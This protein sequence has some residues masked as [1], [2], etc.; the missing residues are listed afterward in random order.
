MKPITT[1]T[2]LAALLATTSTLVWSQQTTGAPVAE[3]AAT[4]TVSAPVATPPATSPEAAPIP[5]RRV[6]APPTANGLTQRWQALGNLLENSSAAKHIEHEGNAESKQLQ[7]D[8]R[9]ARAK[10]KEALDAGELEKSDAL[11]R[12]ASQL[13]FKAERASRS[14]AMAADKAKADYVARRNSV[15]ALMQTGRRIA[16]E[17]HATRPEFAQAEAL[18][19]DADK[20]ADEGKHADGR[21]KLDQA[22]ALITN[23]VR[24]MREGKEVKAEKKFANK[25]EEYTYEQARN[26]D[27]QGLIAGLI[28]DKDSTWTDAAK[29]GTSLREEAD[30]IAK[31]GDHEAALKKINESTNKLKAIL[32][33]SGFPIL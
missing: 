1:S 5:P 7:Q 11:L 21:G 17:E 20:Q 10:A 13:M 15:Q 6:V 32:R 31:S 9:A 12:Q 26:D 19:K 25:A 8:A 23:A 29:L 28:A 14:P 18:I 22:Y 27:Y 30:K 3:S 16:G 2:L 24:G 4:S 33:R